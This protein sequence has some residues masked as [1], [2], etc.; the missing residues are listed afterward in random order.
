[1]NGFELFFV[2]SNS[3]SILADG[4]TS[5]CTINS[6]HLGDMGTEKILIGFK[7]LFGSNGSFYSLR[8]LAPIYDVLS[9]VARVS[10]FT[11]RGT[12]PSI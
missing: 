4:N 8:M 6:V 2:E 7:A 10:E 12:I 5:G 9:G 1:M 11:N 3:I